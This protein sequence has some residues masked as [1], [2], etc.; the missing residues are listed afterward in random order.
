MTLNLA[1]VWT[2]AA[3]REA[4]HQGAPH[5][6]L[7]HLYLGLLQVGGDAARLLGER[8]ISLTLARTHVAAQRGHSFGPHHHGAQVLPLTRR[9]QDLTAEALKR[10]TGTSALLLHL[11]EH[12][13]GTVN[14]LVEAGGVRPA[15]L[16]P[17][18][19][20]GAVDPF[21]PVDVPL[22]TSSLPT[23]AR[24]HSLT[25]YV[26]RPP[27]HV[28]DGLNQPASLAWW[29]YDP[30]TATT[31]GD[32]TVV[33]HHRRG[34]DV[35]VRLHRSDHQQGEARVVVWEADMVDGP[36]AGEPLSHDSFEVGPAPGGSQVTR[37]AGLRSFGL[38]GRV[39]APLTNRVTARTLMMAAATI[40]F[41]V[42]QQE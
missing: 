23:P 1:N 18:L 24:A 40:T 35:T 20:L 7:E 33:R 39:L 8:G 17:A 25:W 5:I 4:A 12:P 15:T 29:A 16:I 10:A 41:G 21:V 30:A 3:D 2:L 28:V 6:D 32:G 19:D 38:L 9:A 36:R 34:Q 13:S 42:N 22:D 26:S 14:A 37:T 31:E 27:A 11:L